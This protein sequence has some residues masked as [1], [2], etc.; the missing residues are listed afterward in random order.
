MV[1][2]VGLLD[3]HVKPSISEILRAELSRRM[4]YMD[5]AMG[6]EIQNLNLNEQDFRGRS[7]KPS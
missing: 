3:Y 4:M 6:T 5:G 2:F 1:S 7:M